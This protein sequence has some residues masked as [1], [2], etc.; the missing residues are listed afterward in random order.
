M[1]YQVTKMKISTLIRLYQKGKLNLNPPYQRNA[2][3]DDASKKLLID[4]IINNFPLP[5]IFLHKISQSRYDMVDGQQRT[6]TILA[7]YDNKLTDQNGK[8]YKD[9]N[10]EKFLD[11]EIPLVKIIKIEKAE[12]IE[13]FYA[14]VNSSG[15]RLNRPELLKAK[16]FGT[17]FMDL[18]DELSCLTE[19]DSLNLFSETSQN[20]MNDLDFTAELIAVIKL[21]RTDKKLKVDDIFEK[22]LTKKECDEIR[23][24]FIGVINVFVKWNNIFRINKTRYKQRN[25][26]YSLFDFINCHITLTDLF[27]KK[28]YNI[29]LVI[30]N[31][32]YP[33]NDDCESFQEYAR[34]CVTQSN[35]KKA[36]DAR[37]NFLKEMFLT[38]YPKVSTTVQ[39]I[40]D[41]YGL[42]TSDITNV[43]GYSM[44]DKSA[45]QNAIE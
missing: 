18:A 31:E 40:M 17:K 24:R 13:A 36:R 29:L 27:Y 10:C 3:W 23:E 41:T 4:T 25:D 33:T 12:K 9:S 39:D 15:K 44:F 16:Y 28:M 19:F 45:L 38:K 22:D 5:S 34:N 35:S 42:E 43:N 37:Y 2:V 21:G 6:R 1:E 32:I 14:R 26:F 11:Y 30:D 8:F 7:Y 20:R